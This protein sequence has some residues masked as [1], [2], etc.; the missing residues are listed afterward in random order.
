MIPS[1]FRI[2][3][4]S[5][6]ELLCAL[7]F[8]G[9]RVNSQ[10]LELTSVS[11]GHCLPPR[12]GVVS[13]ALFLDCSLPQTL[14]SVHELQ[15]PTSQSWGHSAEQGASL[16]GSGPLQGNGGRFEGDSGVRQDTFLY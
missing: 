12:V 15:G 6:R 1:Y 3:I 4:L 2:E 7:G 8:K 5:F 14:H 9:L 11:R 10:F 16:E 13:T